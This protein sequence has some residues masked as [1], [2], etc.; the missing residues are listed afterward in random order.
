MVGLGALHLL[1]RGCHTEMGAKI[2]IKNKKGGGEPQ[3]KGA[4]FQAARAWGNGCAIATAQCNMAKMQK[5]EWNQCLA[6]ESSGLP[7]D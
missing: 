1:P 3:Q 4:H 5:S 7:T 2:K 6:K